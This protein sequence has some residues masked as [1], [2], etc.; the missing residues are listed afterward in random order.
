M[1]AE[2]ATKPNFQLFGTAISYSYPEE[3]L[4]KR[5][6]QPANTLIEMGTPYC[7]HVPINAMFEVKESGATLAATMLR[8]SD[9]AQRAKIV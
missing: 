8:F 4:A 9:E 2:V 5:P 7:F 6:V 3:E 1:L